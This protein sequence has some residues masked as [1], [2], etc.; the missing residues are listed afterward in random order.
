M[1]AST[2]GLLI[3]GGLT[4]LGVLIYLIG[5][6]ARKEKI[7]KI[8]GDLAPTQNIHLQIA[9]PD[10][11]AACLEAELILGMTVEQMRKKAMSGDMA[12]YDN[13]SVVAKNKVDNCKY[14]K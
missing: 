7:K 14:I 9:N 11:V 12:W 2:Q 8:V 10:P 13:L 4:M 6:Q 5:R 3:A 1:K